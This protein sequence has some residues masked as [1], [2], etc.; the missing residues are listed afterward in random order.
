MHRILRTLT[1]IGIGLV[2]L[3]IAAAGMDT[4]DIPAFLSPNTPRDITEIYL[5]FHDEE[6]CREIGAIFKFNKGVLTVLCHVKNWG[7]YNKFLKMLEALPQSYPLEVYATEP[8]ADFKS[9]EDDNLPPSLWENDELRT[10]LWPPPI[11]ITDDSGLSVLLFSP[12]EIF[13]Q[14]LK[15]FAEQTLERASTL[16]HFAGELPALTRLA[17]DSSLNADLKSLAERVCSNHSQKVDKTIDKL[18]DNL[19]QALPG[20]DNVEEFNRAM[21]TESSEELPVVADRI[22]QQSR[23]ISQ[24]VYSFIYPNQHTVEWNDLINPD[25]LHALEELRRS[26]NEYFNRMRQ[27]SGEE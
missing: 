10:L 1:A 26:N 7:S 9:D 19:K 6:M 21:T 13:R 23:N 22:A 15:L 20:N 18:E 11:L 12:E 5:R 3:S 14:R 8:A 25:I 2:G 24:R 4:M 27:I 16:H 17:M